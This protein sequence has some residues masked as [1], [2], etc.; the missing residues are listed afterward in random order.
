ML[1]YVLT[2]FTISPDGLRMV[3]VSAVEF[4]AGAVIPLPF[5]PRKLQLLFEL[6]PI[7]S[8]KKVPLRIYSGSMTEPEMTKAMILQ[9]F[10]LIVLAAGGRALSIFAE[11]K[12]V[13][14]GG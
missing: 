1:V 6:L 7:S 11:K 9:V 2:F 10:W 14:Q 4:F 8:M 12:V 3:F 5:F 13:V